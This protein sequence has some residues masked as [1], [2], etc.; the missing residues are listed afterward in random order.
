MCIVT[1]LLPCT[2]AQSGWG[3]A[4]SETWTDCTGGRAWCLN[5]A[6]SAPKSNGILPRPHWPSEKSPLPPP[7]SHCTPGLDSWCKVW[8]LA[9]GKHHRQVTDGI[10][11]EWQ[12][13]HLAVFLCELIPKYQLNV[14]TK[15]SYRF[16]IWNPCASSNI[17][18]STVCLST[19]GLFL[20]WFLWYRDG[21][22]VYTVWWLSQTL[23]NFN[24]TGIYKAK[25]GKTLLK[26]KL[27][28]VKRFALLEFRLPK[29]YE[30]KVNG[31]KCP[32]KPN[33]Y[34]KVS[35]ESN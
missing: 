12:E 19:L 23:T 1:V 11:Q 17:K 26:F 24:I 8:P 14:T 7:G 4:S 33:I 34:K 27:N 25:W 15:T 6:D 9:P 29:V 13:N 16:H 32:K 30:A 22:P 21:L 10:V 18:C 5:P 31:P 3:C 2:C 35:N 20:W 28:Y